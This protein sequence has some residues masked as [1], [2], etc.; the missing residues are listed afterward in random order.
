MI[1]SEA[2]TIVR[3]NHVTVR[4]QGSRVIVFGHGFGLD[5]S[6]WRHVAPAFEADYRVVTFDY[7]GSGRSDRTAYRSE[8]Y[9]TLQGYAQDLLDIL[10]ALRCEPV[11]FVGASISGMIG[12]LAASKEP[13]R[14]SRLVMVGSSPCYMN[15]PPYRGG[16]NPEDIDGLLD[17]LDQNFVGW[18]ASLASTAIKDP[19]IATELER[20]ICAIDPRVARE[21]AE[22][23]FRCDMRASLPKCQQPVLVIQCKQDDVVPSSASEYLAQK[24]PRSRYRLLQASG[25]CPQLTHPAD[26]R[27]L[28]LNYLDSPAER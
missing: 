5:Q 12:L 23:T 25:H 2:E 19:Q 18:A 6:S 4:G 21:F 28:I 8:R 26:L 17:T 16:F 15:E 3:R 24:L 27:T 22:V 9:A 7:V 1:S 10:A 11:V 13:A 14:F 20:G